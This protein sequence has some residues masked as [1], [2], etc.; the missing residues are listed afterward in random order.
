MKVCVIYVGAY[1]TFD[2]CSSSQKNILFDSMNE[3]NLEYDVFISVANETSFY[4]MSME[5][6]TNNLTK[7]YNST[8]HQL[9]DCPVEKQA[10]GRGHLHYV[11][12]TIDTNE[13]KI[14]FENIVG[15]DNIK[16]F[17]TLITTKPNIKSKNTVS[18]RKGTQVHTLPHFFH[19]AY[20]IRIKRLSK[21]I[22]ICQYDKFIILR[23]EMKLT[24]SSG[25]AKKLLLEKF[26]KGQ[27]YFYIT[28][29]IDFFSISN[30]LFTEFFNEEIYNN[31]YENEDKNDKN[32]IHNIIKNSPYNSFH[33]EV[34]AS[35]LYKKLNVNYKNIN[36]IAGDRVGERL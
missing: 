20:N 9:Q 28:M 22:N 35:N 14:K 10:Y 19:S 12:K 7:F 16:Y 29:R 21:L 31:L 26:N 32:S 25:T 23:P 30:T 18:I 27:N 24:M 13:M 1:N 3:L 5:E 15:K 36:I 2:L 4:N 11:H 34:Y 33:L 6:L 17:D 8:G